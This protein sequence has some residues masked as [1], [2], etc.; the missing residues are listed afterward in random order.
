MSDETRR[1]IRELARNVEKNAPRIERILKARG[2][3]ADPALVF[4]T[5]QYFDCLNRLA[6]E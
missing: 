5:A 1:A 2:K 3:K 4:I 6:K